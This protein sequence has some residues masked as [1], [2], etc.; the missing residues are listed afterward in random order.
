MHLAIFVIFLLTFFHLFRANKASCIK[1]TKLDFI[2][3]LR[4]IFQRKAKKGRNSPYVTLLQHTCSTS[5]GLWR[6]KIE[7][8][9]LLGKI[10][11]NFMCSAQFVTSS[12]VAF[13]FPFH[14]E[15]M[16]LPP[17]LQK[18]SISILLSL[19][20][21]PGEVFFFSNKYGRYIY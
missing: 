2:Y 6:N 9:I 4:K 10:P 17:G 1:M 5:V 21:P 19:L 12:F 7:N 8:F 15:Q 20:C 16:Y 18:F 14:V 11:F 13:V 3:A